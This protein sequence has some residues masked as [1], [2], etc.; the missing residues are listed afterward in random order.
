MTLMNY[1]ITNMGEKSDLSKYISNKRIVQILK[2]NQVHSLRPIQ[3]ATIEKGLFFGSN[4]L[5]CTPSGSGKTLLGELAIVNNV[6]NNLGKGVY[7]VPYKAIANEKW[8][9][10]KKNYDGLG[11]KTALSIGDYSEEINFNEDDRFELSLSE[12]CPGSSYVHIDL[13]GNS[14]IQVVAKDE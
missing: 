4:F 6:F 1:N 8:K 2:S 10:F 13:K 3:I 11:L 5:I 14:Y 9:Y 12:Q 7:L